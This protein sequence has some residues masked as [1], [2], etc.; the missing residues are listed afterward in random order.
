MRQV[1]ETAIIR[2]QIAVQILRD[3]PF[4]PPQPPLPNRART[5]PRQIWHLRSSSVDCSAVV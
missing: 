1:H 5:T 4:S 2:V 3:R